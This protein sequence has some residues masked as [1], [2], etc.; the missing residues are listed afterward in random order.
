[1]GYK[2]IITE[3]QVKKLIEQYDHLCDVYMNIANKLKDAGDD[4]GFVINFSYATAFLKS[5][6]VTQ[7]WLD[8]Q[9]KKK[10]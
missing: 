3:Y 9:L 5:K 7:E 2:K 8:S 10:K 1:M 4:D 6:W